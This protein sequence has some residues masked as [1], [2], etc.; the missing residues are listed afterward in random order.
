M[1]NRAGFEPLHT[2]AMLKCKPLLRQRD[3][4]PRGQRR[5]T[6]NLARLAHRVRDRLA[7]V[8]RN[9]KQPIRHRGAEIHLARERVQPEAYAVKTP[10]VARVAVRVPSR[11]NR[12]HQ[13]SRKAVF[14]QQDRSKRE[15]MIRHDVA[16]AAELCVAVSFV[17]KCANHAPVAG[18]GADIAHVPNQRFQKITCQKSFVLVKQP[19]EIRFCKCRR[20]QRAQK[21]RRF[22]RKAVVRNARALAHKPC[23]ARRIPGAH[24][25][26]A[27]HEDLCA[28]LLR[29]HFAVLF[30]GAALGRGNAAFEVEIRRVLRAVAKPTPPEDGLVLH[31]VV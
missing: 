22:Q 28:D 18:F 8:R 10:D 21:R 12:N 16:T 30:G 13:R 11:R 2:A 26:K 9:H 19:I 6:D 20:F 17:Q 5:R 1:Q 23:R 31:D 7:A 24:H 27:V 4:F 29:Q 25:R 14:A 3:C 15:R